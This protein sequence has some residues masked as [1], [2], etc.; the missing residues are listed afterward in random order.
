MKLIQR[1]LFRSRDLRVDS[2]GSGNLA[3]FSEDNECFVKF[4]PS[5]LSSL[6]SGSSKIV[7][8]H[9]FRSGTAYSKLDR[10]E[11]NED[12]AAGS[13]ESRLMVSESRSLIVV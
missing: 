9:S 6:A 4:G 5:A 2:K 7:T 11:V 1:V 3:S 12:R 10:I 13:R 8:V